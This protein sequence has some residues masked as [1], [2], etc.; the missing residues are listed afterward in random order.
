MDH[1]R[2]C[3]GGQKNSRERCGDGHG[4]TLSGDPSPFGGRL[5]VAA[6]CHETPE[7]GS[8]SRRS[9]AC[10]ARPSLKKCLVFRSQVV[11]S[12]ESEG[13]TVALLQACRTFVTIMRCDRPQL[14]P[15]P[16]VAAVAASIAGNGCPLCSWH[17]QVAAI[18][19][20]HFLAI[21][22]LHHDVASPP[23]SRTMVFSH[24]QAPGS[25]GDTFP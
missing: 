25:P 24:V 1:S 4:P 21:I 13:V 23:A 16:L 15:L 17:L 7:M 3:G 14:L 10:R 2:H 18:C 6:N 11:D 9:G 20:A 19:I 5:Q 8:V 22:S 12:I